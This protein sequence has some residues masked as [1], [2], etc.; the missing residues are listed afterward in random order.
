M[1]SDT[2]QVED[3][4][5]DPSINIALDTILLKKQCIIFVNTKRGAESVAENISKIIL[6]DKKH[7]YQSNMDLEK[8][9][10]V[11]SQI[12]KVLSSPTRQCHRL[13]DLTK[14]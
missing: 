3:R 1:K 11:S 4:N 13:S 2:T 10:I 7:E 9:E 6:K 12:L 14:Y 5:S 8:L